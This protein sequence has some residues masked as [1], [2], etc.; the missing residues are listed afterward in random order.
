MDSE[1]SVG[2]ILHDSSPRIERSEMMPVLRFE[3]KKKHAADGNMKVVIIK[4]ECRS[5]ERVD[6]F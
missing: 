1:P 5:A 4:C 6:M 2:K 3:E